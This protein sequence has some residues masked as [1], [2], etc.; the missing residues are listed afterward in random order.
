MLSVY[1]TLC[2]VKSTQSVFPSHSN[3]PYTNTVFPE[4]EKNPLSASSILLSVLQKA[5]Y[6]GDLFLHLA[7]DF[8]ANHHSYLL[9]KPPPNK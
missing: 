4:G 3:I 2:T 9:R 5:D 8:T 1:G 6:S 7:E